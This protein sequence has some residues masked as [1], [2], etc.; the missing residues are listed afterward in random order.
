MHELHFEAALNWSLGSW[1]FDVDLETIQ[2]GI[3]EQLW[4]KQIQEM[5]INTCSL[6]LNS[7]FI[8]QISVL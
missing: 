5:H 6:V 3:L 7:C 1:S 8:R 4:V 2:H